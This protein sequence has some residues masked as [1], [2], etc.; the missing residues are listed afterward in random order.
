MLISK[1]VLKKWIAHNIREQGYG[2][3]YTYRVLTEDN[4]FR[5]LA[6]IQAMSPGEV[7][8]VQVFANRGYAPSSLFK[9]VIPKPDEIYLPTPV[10]NNCRD[11]QRERCYR[12]E[13]QMVYRF[14]YDYPRR[15]TL[16]QCIK[17]ARV[18]ATDYALGFVPEIEI[19]KRRK[20]TS[21]S[22][23]LS[24]KIVLAAGWGQSKKVVL[25][26]LAHQ[27]VYNCNGDDPGHGRHFVT[28]MMD[29]YEKHLGWDRTI[30]KE[31]LLKNNVEFLEE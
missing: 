5:K 25:H 30:M 6:N 12:A 21:I 27:I 31:I 20:A 28:T 3:G 29:L 16:E 19:S 18:V 24:R 10:K 13:G 26:E 17:L 23:N 9:L 1:T 22:Y 2:S 11:W 7:I 4:Q 14:A 15:L 8:H